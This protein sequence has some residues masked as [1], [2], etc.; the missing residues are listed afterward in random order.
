MDKKLFDA[1]QEQ[2]PKFNQGVIDGFAVK[3]FKDMISYLERIVRTIVPDFP[4]EL[5]FVGIRRC[6]PRETFRVI[7]DGQVTK[8]SYELSR[9]DLY[10]V[11]LLLTYNG[12][13]MRPVYFYLPYV[14][15]GGLITL[16]GAPYQISPV[17][18]D[19]S[20][21]VTTNEI[22]IP[23]N[24]DRVRFWRQG[25]MFVKD[26]QVIT[27]DVVYTPLHHKGKKNR[28]GN[29]GKT[30]LVHYL[31]AE[32]GVAMTFG[33]FAGA[34]VHIGEANAINAED[35]PPDKFVICRSARPGGPRYSPPT[36]RL[37]IPRHHYE[38]NPAVQSL[39]AG[40]F[41]VADLFPSRVKA[42]FL[43]DD[44]ERRLWMVLLGHLIWGNEY[45][46]GMLYELM[47]IHQD[48][49]AGYVDSEVREALKEDGIEVNDIYGLFMH[50]VETFSQRV[51]QSSSRV[52]SMYGKRL[53]ILR[54]VTQDIVTALN[55]FMYKMK[56]S[57]KKPLGQDDIQR[58]AE[59]FIKTTKI[60]ELTQ[61][62]CEV[63]SASTPGDNKY[64]KIT[65]HIVL[66]ADSAA[67]GRG[68][69]RKTT[70]SDPSKFLHS[71]IAEVSSYNTMQKSEPTGRN[72]IGPFL[73]TTEDGRIIR[74][75]ELVELMDRTQV[76]IQ[77]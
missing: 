3:H 26:D 68:G 62:H 45:G 41:Y 69:K 17:L 39:V 14:K 55:M 47:A 11:K 44:D 31:F 66:Q 36:V 13:A 72:K 70:S 77:R 56:A 15:D 27:S 43:G 18:A 50:I 7:T 2:M 40:F 52:S 29:S 54:Y 76:Q 23:M 10:M 73:H 4:P 19:P 12:H 53:M 71:S 6:T 65:S 48:S 1:I 57:K 22:F 37:A 30:S 51:A 42:E 33:M 34:A 74:N 64:W 38:S 61:D 46:E 58:M 63:T 9:S 32:Y 24:R 67:K 25:A 75:P 59:D 60:M 49:I 5:G 28:G 16:R 20:L 35:F 21:S 8:K